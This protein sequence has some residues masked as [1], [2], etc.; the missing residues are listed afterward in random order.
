MSQ[1]PRK[2]KATQ[3][4][5]VV[6]R[7]RNYFGS[8]FHVLMSSLNRLGRAPIASFMTAA[9]IGIALALPAA[10]HVFLNKLQAVSSVWQESTQVTVFLKK[11]VADGVAL[12]LSR[13]LQRWPEITKVHYISPGR[14]LKEFE[15]HSGMTDVVGL[16]NENPLPGVLVITPSKSISAIQTEAL[17]PKLQKLS[18]VESAQMDVEWVRRLHGLLSVSERAVLT[19][20][21]LLALAVLFIIGNTI[22]LLIQNRQD[23]VEVVKLIGGSNAF[24]RRPFLY[25]GIWFGLFGGM[26]AWLLVNLLLAALSGPVAQLASLYGSDFRLGYADLETTAILLFIGPFL[27]LVGAWL[28]SGRYLRAIE[29]V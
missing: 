3:Q 27:G 1:P 18:G 16:L 13:E 8:H 23:E 9:V 6:A 29:P 10:V 26:V 5:V 12:A 20:G 28:V 15:Q 7:V 4:S 22:R 11:D 19:F 14:A 24:V 25:T 17:L 2:P 21:G